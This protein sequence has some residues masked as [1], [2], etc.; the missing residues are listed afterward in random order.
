MPAVMAQ[1]ESLRLQQPL[2]EPCLVVGCNRRFMRDRPLYLG[3]ST[4][5]KEPNA[6]AHTL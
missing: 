3:G 6:T 2:N 1:R 4:R 5:V